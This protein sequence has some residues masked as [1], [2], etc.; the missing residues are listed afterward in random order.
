MF[1][2]NSIRTLDFDPDEGNAMYR[3]MSYVHDMAPEWLRSVHSAKIV[4]SSRQA[5][6]SPLSYSIALYPTRPN[7]TMHLAD[8]DAS[9]LTLPSKL[10]LRLIT[11]PPGKEISL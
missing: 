11:V 8:T 2:S 9:I 10:V 1:V 7:K 5:A 4:R 6:R 3:Y